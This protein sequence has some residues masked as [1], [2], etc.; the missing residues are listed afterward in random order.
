MWVRRGRVGCV[1]GV[2]VGAGCWGGVLGREVGVVSGLP[3]MLRI[4][5]AP[6]YH[7]DTL[8]N[9]DTCLGFFNFVFK[10]KF[11]NILTAEIMEIRKKLR[12]GKSKLC[13][14]F[15]SISSSSSCPLLQNCLQ[16][17]E[18]FVTMMNGWPICRHCLVVVVAY[19]WSGNLKY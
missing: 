13:K 17:W 9:P 18:S 3:R 16:S 7:P 5:L 15:K 4:K 19:S 8:V 14:G 1:V 11:S 12:L 2:A 6:L 10:F